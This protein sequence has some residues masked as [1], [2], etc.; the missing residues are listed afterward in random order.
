M[1]PVT[2][3]SGRISIIR[4]SQD[5]PGP[6]NDCGVKAIKPMSKLSP[7]VIIGQLSVGISRLPYSRVKIASSARLC[8]AATT[9]TVLALS[10]KSVQANAADDASAR[11]MAA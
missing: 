9:W 10:C 1:E 3:D 7:G 6:V 11:H 5:V 8:G 2:T 4:F